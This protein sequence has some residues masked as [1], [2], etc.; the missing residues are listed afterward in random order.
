MNIK[1]FTPLYLAMLIPALIACGSDSGSSNDSAGTVSADQDADDLSTE[2]SAEVLVT[3]GEDGLLTPRI[4]TLLDDNLLHVFYYDDYTGDSETAE[5]DLKYLVW[6][7]DSS[8]FDTEPETVVSIDNSGSLAAAL[9]LSNNGQVIYQGGE[10]RECQGDEQSDVMVSSLDSSD[11]L[12]ET[13]SIGFVERQT[14]EPLQDGLAGGQMSMAIDN[15][16]NRHMVYQFYYEGCDTFGMEYPDLK[17]V[18]LYAGTDY[19]DRETVDN[20]SHEEA[21]EANVLSTDDDS[22]FNELVLAGEASKILINSDGNPVVAYSAE[23]NFGDDDFIGLKL[24]VRESGEW[25]SEWLVDD[26][27]VEALDAAYND[28]GE[29]GIAYYSNNCDDERDTYHQLHYLESSDGEWS[30]TTMNTTMQIGQ[31]PSLAFDSDGDPVIAYYEI[32]T[33]AGNEQEN[34]RVARRKDGS[35]SL[36]EVSNLDEIGKYNQLQVTDSGEAIL[37]TYYESGNQIALFRSDL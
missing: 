23:D 28:D 29:L 6:N 16:G 4:Q 21:I 5:A 20:D 35:W 30:H 22:E 17:Y 19:S 25:S 32:E 37:V 27:E 13:A 8:S 1:Q 34:L 10:N 7:L 31:Y 15:D 36:N 3:L 11:W 18:Q 24:A 26:C 9:D 33:Y 2:W 12:E 14:Y